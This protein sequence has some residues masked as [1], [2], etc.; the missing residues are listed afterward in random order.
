MRELRRALPFVLGLWLLFAVGCAGIVVAGDPAPRAFTP[1]ALAS[2]TQVSTPLV[3]I[4]Q[5][6]RPPQASLSPE[7]TRVAPTPTL[8]PT[9]RPLPTA[10]PAKPSSATSRRAVGTVPVLMYHYIRVNPDPTDKIGFGLS[11]TPLD[12]A[13]QMA[14]LAKRGY[15]TVSLDQLGTPEAADGKAVV[16]TFDDG[17]ADAYDQAFPVLRQNGFKATFYLITG[18]VGR[19]RYLTWDQ[20]RALAAAG[21]V[22]GSHT[23][24]HPDLRTLGASDVA[25]QLKNSRA[26]L[27]REV[28][29][30]VLDFSYPSGKYNDAVE[31]AVVAAGYKTAVTVRPG[32]ATAGDD[33]LALAR[34]R[35][36]GG[37]TLADF[38]AAIGEAAP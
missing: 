6:P 17:Y 20:A 28:G 14:F 1:S 16:I 29:R 38:A 11:V 8:T 27:E 19:P 34:V 35:I 13:A 36:S 33:R 26:Q 5:N 10:P 3:P 32:F 9:P 18:L 31:A 2:P 30:P 4:G 23:V 21:Q 25:A 22:I 7:G 37:M 12:F 24:D 15:H